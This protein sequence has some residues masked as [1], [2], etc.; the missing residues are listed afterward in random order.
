MLYPNERRAAC[1]IALLFNILWTRARQVEDGSAIIIDDDGEPQFTN[2]W[3]YA[4]DAARCA[5]MANGTA[6]LYSNPE[7][8]QV[9]DA[10]GRHH[11]PKGLPSITNSCHL[12]ADSS[13]VSKSARSSNDSC[14]SSPAGMIDT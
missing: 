13:S 11:K 14:C 3:H 9:I 2:R 12:P 4:F 10:M 5:L 1:A 6:N 8:S 7:R